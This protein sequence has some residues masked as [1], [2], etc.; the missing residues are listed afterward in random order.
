MPTRSNPWGC[1]LPPWVKDITR[2]VPSLVQPS[3]Y[4]P[5]LI[6]HVGGDDVATHSPRVIRKEF[7]ALGWLVGESGAQVIFYSILPA[8]G[9]NTG[10][11]KRTKSIN[12]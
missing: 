5:L 4:F 2:K 7:R 12:T 10:R 1:L 9:S 8:E 11:S 3:D 6:F